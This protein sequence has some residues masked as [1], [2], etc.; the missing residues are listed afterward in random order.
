ME[1]ICV[2]VGIWIGSWITAKIE[3]HR[4]ISKLNETFLKVEQVLERLPPEDFQKIED[5][6]DEEIKKMD[7][8][9]NERQKT[10]KKGRVR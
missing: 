7:R 5:L 6:F 8:E 10:R 1:T 9:E 3:S 4:W 2:F